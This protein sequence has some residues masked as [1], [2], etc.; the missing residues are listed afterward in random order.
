MN[1]WFDTRRKSGLNEA[2][3]RSI[4]TAGDELTVPHRRPAAQPLDARNAVS[5]SEQ[6]HHCER[7]VDFQTLAH[8]RKAFPYYPEEPFHNIS[9]HI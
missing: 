6:I 8:L 4:P 3:A 1:R 2:P 9:A 7:R 5:L